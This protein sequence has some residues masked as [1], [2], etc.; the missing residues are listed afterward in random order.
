MPKFPRTEQESLGIDAM[1]H[2][3]AATKKGM[4]HLPTTCASCGHSVHGIHADTRKHK[5]I[6]TVFGREAISP[7]KNHV[8]R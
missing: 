1:D 4:I 5:L 2:Y 3:S 6:C 7:C 8:P